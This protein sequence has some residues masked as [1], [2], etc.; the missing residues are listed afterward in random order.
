[1]STRSLGLEFARL[2]GVGDQG[3]SRPG[4]INQNVKSSELRVPVLTQFQ[5]YAGSTIN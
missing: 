2:D 3:L 5:S 4:G 1:M